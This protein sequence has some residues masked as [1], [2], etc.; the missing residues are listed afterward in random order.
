MAQKRLTDPTVKNLP[1][2]KSGQVDYFDTILP[3]F[4]VRVSYGG[5]RTWFVTTRIAGR[6]KVARLKVGRFPAMSLAQAREKARLMLDMAGRGIDP[7]KL[8]EQEIE[9]NAKKAALTFGTISQEFLDKYAP[10]RKLRPATV[11]EYKRTFEIVC[12]DWREKPVADLTRRDLNELLDAIAARGKGVL[13]D[14]TFAYLRKFFGWCVDRDYL[15]SSPADK[16]RRQRTHSSR[17]RV[18]NAGEIKILWNDFEGI[19]YPFG[20]LLKLLLLTGQRKSEVAGMEWGELRDWSTKPL[21]DI[22]GARTKN[23]RAH[24]VPIVP[25]A[26]AIIDACPRVGP[27]VFTTTGQTPVSGFSRVKGTVGLDIPHWTLH[28]LRRTAVTVMNERLGIAPYIVE[29]VI[30]HISGSRAGVAGV[31]NRARYLDER[32]VALEAW[33]DWIMRL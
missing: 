18:L 20:P 26:R 22:P 1:V 30:N 16:V 15:E 24:L 19:G 31:Y 8:R 6:G 7:R 2:P 14:R 13:V 12:A 4:G 23:G 25:V 33:A 5:S 28:D 29:E 32:R 11:R 17:E 10:A 9:A 27:H 21:W 3:A